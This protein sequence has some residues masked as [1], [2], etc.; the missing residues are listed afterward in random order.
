MRLISWFVS[1]VLLSVIAAPVM[2][3]DN[4][5]I[6]T[7]LNYA[8]VTENHKILNKLKGTWRGTGS[9]VNA[10]GGAAEKILCKSTNQ[11]I[12]GGRFIE[13]KNHL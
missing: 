1:V 10:E 11:M 2:A 8:R 6:T 12:L 7:L 13:Q 3:A 9:L 5:K 4:E